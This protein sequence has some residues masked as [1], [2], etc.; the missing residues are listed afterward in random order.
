VQSD[1]YKIKLV[2]NSMII[3]GGGIGGLAAALA[4]GQAGVM[5][6]V[7]ERAATFQKWGRVSKWAPM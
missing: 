5:P 7:L 1:R 2:E 6:Q 3:V 4:S